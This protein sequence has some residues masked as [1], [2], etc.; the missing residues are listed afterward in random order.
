VWIAMAADECFAGSSCCCAGARRVAQIRAGPAH[1]RRRGRLG[2]A[3]RS[4]GGAVA[5]FASRGHTARMAKPRIVSAEECSGPVTS[6]SRP[7]SKYAR[8]RC[9]GRPAPPPSHG[10]AHDA[11]RVRY[12]GR[13]ADAGR[14]VR[15]PRPAVV[16]Q[17][18]DARPDALLPGLHRVHHNVP[19][20]G[21]PRLAEHGVTWVTASNMPLAQIEAYKARMG[22]TLRSCRRAARRSPTIAAPAAAS[23]SARS[24][25]TVM[26]SIVPTPPRRAAWIDCYLPIASWISPPMAARR[27]GRTRPPAGRSTRPT[28]KVARR[29]GCDG[30]EV[31]SE[32]GKVMAAGGGD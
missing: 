20:T 6:C 22:W 1:R 14:P 7:R 28:D 18:M 5:R 30:H 17:F 23:C 4:R 15:G 3:A 8:A 32:A 25:A 11:V 10:Q 21:L 13:H 19:V 2:G 26:I 16:Y 29:P 27:I 24:C 9:A 31:A 12:A